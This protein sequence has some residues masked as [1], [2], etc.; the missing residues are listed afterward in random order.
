MRAFE[1]IDNNRKAKTT[2]KAIHKHSGNLFASVATTTTTTTSTPIQSLTPTP[3][4]RFWH[5][6]TRIQTN[7]SYVDCLLLLLLLLLL[8][9]CCGRAR[10]LLM[11]F[12]LFLFHFVDRWA[13]FVD[14]LEESLLES[15]HLTD[16]ID[17]TTI[18][19]AQHSLGAQSHTFN[20]YK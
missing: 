15:I 16:S 1:Y 14:R 11:R 6:C 13:N 17:T 20:V 19:I 5:M 10:S 4:H 3:Y 18:A 7:W 2:Y 8:L 9:C 12:W